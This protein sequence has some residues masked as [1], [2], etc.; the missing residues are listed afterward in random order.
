[1]MDKKAICNILNFEQALVE[2]TVSEE[3]RRIYLKW[4]R[5]GGLYE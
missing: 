5:R 2:L 3:Y 1:M 4:K